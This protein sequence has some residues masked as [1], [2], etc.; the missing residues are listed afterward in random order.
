M[1]KLFIAIGIVSVLAF[2]I[3][4]QYTDLEAWIKMHNR[5]SEK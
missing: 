2:Y 5:K 3:L 1:I 4:K